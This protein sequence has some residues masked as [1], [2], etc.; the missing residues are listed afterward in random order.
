V[1]FVPLTQASLHGLR[2]QIPF[3]QRHIHEAPNI[4]P[5]GHLNADE[6][7]GL[8]QHYGLDYGPLT[9]GTAPVGTSGPADPPELPA[10]SSPPSPTK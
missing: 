1:T 8:Y 5:D 6:E 10:N 3:L 2:V 7:A 4:D 9:P